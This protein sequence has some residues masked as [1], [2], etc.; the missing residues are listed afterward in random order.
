MKIDQ[1]NE[2]SVWAESPCPNGQII[3]PDGDHLVCDVKLMAIRRFSPAGKFL[4]NEIEGFCA[5]IPV[6]TPN[7]LIADDEISIDEVITAVN[8][9]L[10]ACPIF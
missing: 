3:L 10:S 8:V 4:R 5:D 6:Y 1:D 7:D 2:V 9:A